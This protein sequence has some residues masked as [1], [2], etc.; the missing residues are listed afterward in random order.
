MTQQT[1]CLVFTGTNAN[2]CDGE[3]QENKSSAIE[4]HL[5]FY[6]DSRQSTTYMSKETLVSMVVSVFLFKGSLEL[7][8]S[9]FHDVVGGA[10]YV[11][12][13]L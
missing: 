7:F 2:C 1:T 5:L 4:N 9:L 13:F 8:T 3:D 6:I 11:Y 12:A 10:K